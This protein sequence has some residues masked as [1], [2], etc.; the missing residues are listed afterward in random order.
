MDLY[1]NSIKGEKMKSTTNT[2]EIELN[3]LLKKYF[4]EDELINIDQNLNSSNR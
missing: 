1:T 2:F 4:G 3:S